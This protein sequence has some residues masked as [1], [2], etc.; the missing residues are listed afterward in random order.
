MR[1]IGTVVAGI[2]AVA[3]SGCGGGGG[4]A[5]VEPR[6]GAVGPGDQAFAASWAET[7][8]PPA[9]R[10]GITVVGVGSVD[11][12][13]DVA[14]WSFGVRARAATAQAA[15]DE[16]AAT[17]ERLLAALRDAGIGQ[18]DLRTEHVSLYPQM[19]DEYAEEGEGRIL[20][21]V[22]SNTVH[23]TVRDLAAA[24]AV[25]DAAVEAGANEVYGPSFDVGDTSASYARALEA[26]YDNARA[27]GETVA[28]RAGVR[29]GAPIAIVEG[30]GGGGGGG[31]PVYEAEAAD[32]AGVPIEAGRGSMTATVTVTFAIA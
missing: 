20:G 27:R 16:V 11:V 30:A 10:D 24:G 5:A 4:G 23:A 13:P 7:Q 28:G 12:A 9:A 19:R 26:A 6:S 29:L 21:Y 15:M 25:V 2:A 1:L 3:L 31:E 14:G 22:A 18:D 32:A 17:T 8:G